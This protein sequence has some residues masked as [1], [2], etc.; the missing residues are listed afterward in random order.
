MITWPINMLSMTTIQ[1]N[2]LDGSI[3]RVLVDDLV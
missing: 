3:D 1:K 2:K